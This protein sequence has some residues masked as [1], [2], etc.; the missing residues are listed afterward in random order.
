MKKNTPIKSTADASAR[1]TPIVSEKDELLVTAWL[2]G[3]LPPEA[4]P[5]FESRLN[6]GE[7][8]LLKEIELQS[9]VRKYVKDWYQEKILEVRGAA[10]LNV[11]N[12]IE[13]ELRAAKRVK[14]GLPFR[15]ILKSMFEP[16]MLGGLA[17][18]AAAVMLFITSNG[19]EPSRIDGS[20]NGAI[21]AEEKSSESLEAPIVVSSAP[22]AD[23]LLTRVGIG[24]LDESDGRIPNALAL[25]LMNSPQLIVNNSIPG[26]LRAGDTDIDW[27]KT[28]KPFK[29]VPSKNHDQTP[30]IWVARVAKHR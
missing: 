24:K 7:Q 21:V 3:E 13:G 4:L 20:M 28:E 30:V 29:L 19:K 10:P 23:D 11:W 1:T 12:K 27:I 16:R 22:V 6:S 25:R 17:A 15:Q 9:E 14:P 5:A 18:C 8:S 26:G 2:D